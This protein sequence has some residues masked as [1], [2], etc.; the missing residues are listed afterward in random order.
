MLSL[1]HLFLAIA[2]L[3]AA[4]MGLAAPS[5][6]EDSLAHHAERD[7]DVDAAQFEQRDVAEEA[8][9]E[10]EEDAEDVLDVLSGRAPAAGCYTTSQRGKNCHSAQ[11]PGRTQCK[12]NNR[13][14]CVW[15]KPKRQRPFGC[16]QCR[17][18]KFT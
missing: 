15:A 7:L 8:E 5:P 18:A 2:V 16:S 10:E 17:C 1:R 13:G 9:A 3:G 11:C 4:P 12:L 14:R 6:A